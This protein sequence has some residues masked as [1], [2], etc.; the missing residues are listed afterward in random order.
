MDRR[1]FLTVL[2]AA[3]FAGVPGAGA[4]AGSRPQRRDRTPPPPTAALVTRWDVDPW[5]R[6]AYSALP[7]GTRPGVRGTL[8]NAVIGG[9]IALAG[10]YAS[11]EYPS[12]TTGA[13]LSGRHAA[14]RLMARRDPRTAIVI[15]AGFA[16]ASAASALAAAGVRVTVLEATARIGGRV[17]ADRSFGAPIELG[18]AW[19]HGA[20]GNPVYAL[21]RKYGLRLEPARYGDAVVRD[22]ETGRTSTTGE[23]AW[24]RIE[25]VLEP[26][27]VRPAPVDESVGGWLRSRDWPNG[28][29]ATW[30]T[31]VEVVQEYGLDARGL[32]TRAYYEGSEYRGGDVFVAGGYATIASRLLDDIDVRFEAAVTHVAVDGASVH[33]RMQD[34]RR[35][36]ADV[37]V[38]AVPLALLQ[39]GLPRIAGVPAAV[40]VALEGLRTGNLEKVALRYDDQ[41][42]GSQRVIGVVGGGATGAPPGSSAALRWT[43]FYSLTDVVGMPVLVGFAG[44][45]AATRRPRTDAGCI[46]EATAAL[47]AAFRG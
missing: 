7:V 19:I 32:G 14:S 45:S 28:R 37:V 43:E 24:S 40:R 12:T 30:A 13:Y 29:F 35:M 34:G 2:G 25:R 6:G 26:L 44:G 15:G 1:S 46:R 3:A 17:R 42:W 38:V 47:A 4:R 5:A 22:T 10:E 33:V 23:R 36:T 21:A 16:G 27:S 41:W 18:A 11:T 20:A 39:A 31:Q 8:A 9:R